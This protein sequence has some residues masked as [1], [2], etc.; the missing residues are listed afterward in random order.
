MKAIDCDGSIRHL[1]VG[2]TEDEEIESND[3][4]VI[5]FVGGGRGRDGGAIGSSS[6]LV[7][8]SG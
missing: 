3:L 4:C 1:Q 5:P 8:W 7:W 6:S 2:P